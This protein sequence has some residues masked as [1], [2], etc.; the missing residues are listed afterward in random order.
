M[1]IIIVRNF[2]SNLGQPPLRI[3]LDSYKRTTTVLSTDG[4]SGDA[5][6]YKEMF[7][8]RKESQSL[9][10]TDRNFTDYILEKAVNNIK[11]VD[12]EYLI[13]ATI[14]ERNYTAWFNNKAYHTA[15]LTLNTLFNA[16]LR[17]VCPS[18]EMAVINKPLPYQPKTRFLRLQ[19][20]NNLGFQL[21]FNTGFAMSF[22]A[23]IYIMFYIKVAIILKLIFKFKCLIYIF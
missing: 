11:E 7:E 17:T 22:V 14:S 4:V 1:T 15:P 3:T 21:S 6:S 20:G 2:P 9:V 23:A 8:N 5:Q 19:G 16:M 13:G 10:I 12:N 18:C